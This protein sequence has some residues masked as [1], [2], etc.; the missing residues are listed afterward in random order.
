MLQQ[1]R[2]LTACL[3]NAF[4]HPAP[5][6]CSSG[7]SLPSFHMSMTFGRLGLLEVQDKT[8]CQICRPGRRSCKLLVSR[9]KMRFPLCSTALPDSILLLIAKS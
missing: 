5:A 4:D 6:L 2:V 3:L 8:A 1:E 9:P 7:K